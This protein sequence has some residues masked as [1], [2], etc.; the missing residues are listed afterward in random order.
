MRRKLLFVR[1]KLLIV[2]RKR[3]FVLR[4]MLPL[5]FNRHFGARNSL[6]KRRPSHEFLHTFG[7]KLLQTLS[8]LLHRAF[9]FG[10]TL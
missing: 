5:A 1:R 2:T 10:M 3:G 7:T 8:G 9:A 6:K 4:A